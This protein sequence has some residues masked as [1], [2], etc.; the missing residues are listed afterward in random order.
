[1]KARIGLVGGGTG[2]HFYPLIAISES[3]REQLPGVELYYY[4][5][6]PYQ[7][8]QLDTLQIRFRKVTAGKQRR[9]RSRANFFDRFKILFGALQGIIRLYVDY[10]DVIVSKGGYTSVPVVLAAKFLRIPI[11][12]HESDAVPGRANQ[13]ATRFA[14]YIAISYDDAAEHFPADKTALTGIPIRKAFFEPIANP[15]ATLGIDSALPILFVTG[16]SSG[17]ERLNTLVL[18]TLDELL[19]HFTIIHQVGDANVTSVQETAL[20]RGFSDELMSRYFVLGSLTAEQMAAAQEAATLIISRA[21]STSIFE[22]ALKGK[23]SII[24]PIPESVSH[25]QR[26]NAYAYARSGAATVME[27]ENLTDGLLAAEVKRI[28]EDERVY[29]AMANAARQFTNPD[30]AAKLAGTVLGIAAEH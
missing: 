18:D 1:M 20:A 4:G 28:V 3:L 13:F 8:G 21:G 30:A 23:P 29:Q 22:I 16:G 24:I 11:V 5:P 19:P 17:A 6:D 9:Y 25:D 14:R 26:T 10:P 27:E 12:I 2:G 15:Q 7:K